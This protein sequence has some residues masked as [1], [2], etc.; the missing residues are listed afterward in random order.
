MK[1]MTETENDKAIKELANL[2]WQAKMRRKKVMLLA[3]C[4]LS[5][6]SG[7]PCLPSLFGR[8]LMNVERNEDAKKIRTEE[9][10]F[11]QLIF[12]LFRDGAMYTTEWSNTIEWFSKAVETATPTKTHDIILQ[13]WAEQYITSIVSLNYDDL[14][15]RACKE[16]WGDNWEKKCKIILNKEDGENFLK[17]FSIQLPLIKAHGDLWMMQCKNCKSQ[18]LITRGIPFVFY[19]GEK[20]RKCG[21]TLYPSTFMPDSARKESQDFIK[22]FKDKKEEFDVVVCVGFSG[23]YDTHITDMLKDFQDSG[24]KI[25]NI[26]TNRTTLIFSDVLIALKANEAFNRLQN[27]IAILKRAYEAKKKDLELNHTF[28]DA[29]YKAI[30]L[31][32]IEWGICHSEGFRNLQGFH[33]LGLKYRKFIS[34]THTRFE[35][36]LGVMQV[37][38]EMY[39]SLHQIGE[40]GKL[41]PDTNRHQSERQFLR[42]A[43]LLHDIGHICFGHLGEETIDDLFSDVGYEFSH[44]EFAEDVLKHSNLKDL[45]ED[46]FLR[47]PP[48]YDELIKWINDET[49][50][51]YSYYTY[52]DLIKLIKGESKIGILD[53]I[54][55]SPFDAD[56]LEY[57]LRDSEM[58]GRGY[59][60]ELDKEIFLNNLVVRNGDLCIREEAISALE[61]VVEARYHM[62]KEV[63]A[64]PYVRGYE[65]LF[66]WALKE[67]IHHHGWIKI[68][69]ERD[70]KWIMKNL[71][72]DKYDSVIINEINTKIN[73]NGVQFFN[74]GLDEVNF[75]KI[76]MNI[77]SGTKELPEPMV[78]KIRTGKP[79]ED[80]ETILQSLSSIENSFIYK[81]IIDTYVFD[82]IG[83]RRNEPKIITKNMKLKSVDEL[84]SFI[85]ALK[86]AY[87]YKIRVYLFDEN[88]REKV[89]KEIDKKLED[90]GVNI[91]R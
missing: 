84:S 32:D 68:G 55:D 6:E 52:K 7:A 82:P 25:V 70:T 71:I 74:D 83:G 15:E 9:G 78:L 17:A 45:L 14:I 3:G 16:K 42:L 1:M 90:T 18:Q 56:K 62:Y 53:K 35:H 8:Y 66:K 27:Y 2:L 37:A 21:E 63:Y 19:K 81:V 61:R 24:V 49:S 41:K 38:D 73:S 36:S 58:T 72:W 26:N 33:Q 40:K 54:I 50:V 86:I 13:L 29:V 5:K 65:T 80:I 75:L 79:R 12:K 51:G 76:A 67:W 64:D 91:E 87:D 88:I 22:Y 85:M 43:A 20:C 47:R 77:I 44:T 46:K 23:R 48:S 4:G 39:L 10:Y 69:D 60:I 34:A 11:N 28:F 31:T 30:N 57:L 89:L 59:G